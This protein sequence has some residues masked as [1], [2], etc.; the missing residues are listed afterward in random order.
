MK[1]K[2]SV[3]QRVQEAGTYASFIVAVASPL[4]AVLGFSLNREL[5]YALVALILIPI[6]YLIYQYKV[7]VR[8]IEEE[9]GRS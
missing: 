2:E 4:A 6:V 1:T 5:F 9:G 8:K 7:A 3:L